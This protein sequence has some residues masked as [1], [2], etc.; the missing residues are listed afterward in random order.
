MNLEQ[1]ANLGEFLG[2]VAVI[3]SLIYVAI[4]LRGNRHTQRS[5]SYGRSLEMLRDVQSRFATN[6]EYARV[7]NR[8]MVEPETLSIEDRLKF[9]WACTEMFGAFEYMHYQA[10]QGDMPEEIWL[11]WERTL[12]F[13]M[14]YPGIQTWW[15]GKPTVFSP[16]FSALC[17]RFMQEPYEP[18]RPGAW[19]E[20]LRAGTVA[21]DKR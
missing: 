3:T 15:F 16:T 18:E 5:D 14:T 11:R 7:Y 10:M 17:E 12:R 19:E 4:Q 20:W 9:T 2:G 6:P 13:W 1:L 8:G 21:A